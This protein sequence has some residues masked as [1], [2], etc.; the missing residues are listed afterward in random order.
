MS[1]IFK[2]LVW[3]GLGLNPKPCD[4]W[5]RALQLGYMIAKRGLGFRNKRVSSHAPERASDLATCLSTKQPSP[6]EPITISAGSIPCS[7]AH[8]NYLVR[9]M[10]IRIFWTCD[11]LRRPCAAAA[12][13][14]DYWMWSNST[15]L[16]HMKYTRITNNSIEINSF[17]IHSKLKK[18][19]ITFERAPGWYK[20]I[21]GIRSKCL[22]V[23]VTKFRQVFS[24]NEISL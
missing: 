23:E 6:K 2:S 3:L 16:L 21:L 19:R 10:Q 15:K 5:A 22:V 7:D 9:R 13:I 18:S 11:N 14:Q 20:K 4:S 12:C 1:N 24:V 17:I 8:G